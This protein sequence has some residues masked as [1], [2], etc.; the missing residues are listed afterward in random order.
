M[1]TIDRWAPVGP[2]SLSRTYSRSAPLARL[3][4]FVRFLAVLPLLGNIERPLSLPASI[5]EAALKEAQRPAVR[6]TG[7]S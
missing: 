6:V 5:S 3:Y 7:G 2:I 1:T 4:Y